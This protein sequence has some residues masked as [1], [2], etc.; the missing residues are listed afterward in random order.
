MIGE[1]ASYKGRRVFRA[2]VTM[3]VLTVGVTRIFAVVACGVYRSRGWDWMS[4][5]MT[6]VAAIFGVGGIVV[7]QT[8]RSASA[9]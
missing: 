9:V 8:F 7:A 3:T 2:G 1:G 6:L 5:G 4:I